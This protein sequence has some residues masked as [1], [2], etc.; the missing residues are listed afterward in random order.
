MILRHCGGISV[1]C[2]VLITYMQQPL[3]NLF[4]KNRLPGFVLFNGEKLKQTKYYHSW[5]R[6][7]TVNISFKACDT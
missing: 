7:F 6:N 5:R 3:R 1:K 2:E 4:C